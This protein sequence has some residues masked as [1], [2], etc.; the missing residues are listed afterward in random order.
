MIGYIPALQVSCALLIETVKPL[1]NNRRACSPG[2]TSLTRWSQNCNGADMP[3]KVFE[4][5]AAAAV[6]PGVTRGA[7]E[8]VL[9]PMAIPATDMATAAESRAATGREEVNCM[10]TPILWGYAP[11]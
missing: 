9:A 10:T 7:A 5:G 1:K 8:A 2:P 11:S 3:S 4:T 6:R